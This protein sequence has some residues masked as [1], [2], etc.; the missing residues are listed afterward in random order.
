M[1]P[2]IGHQPVRLG[3]LG[4]GRITRALL[5][6]ARRTKAVE[7]VA[8]GSRTVERA[9]E[10][11]AEQ[12]IARS[13]GSY[14]AFLADP[15]VEA[16]YI[17]LPNSLH[18]PWTL[19]ALEAGTHV[20]CEKPYSRRPADVVTAFDAADRAGLVLTEGFM[21]RHHPQ[22]RTIGEL[23]A[24]L[25]ELQTVRATFSFVIE[26]Q[27]DV[28][29]RSD[30]DGGSLMDV[31][32]YCISGARLL[33]GEEPDLAFGVQVVGPTGVD[34]RFNGLLHFPGGAIAEFMS[35]FEADHRGLEAIGSD[36]SVRLTNPWLPEDA[37]YVRDGVE[38]PFGTFDPY[39]LELQDFSRAIR[40]RRPPLLGR[41]DALG[42]ARAI[43]ALYRSAASGV[44]IR[45]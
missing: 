15:D 31:G 17:S 9:A 8:V 41:A 19:R 40:E 42:Q 7:V 28:R 11:A 44:P 4:T 30:L 45:L 16:V 12:G 3:I 35:G 39:Q 32:T 21:W 6:G 36:G 2:S 37:S 20:L 25:G 18:H 23:L 27:S 26:H 13:H 5:A 33:T 34:V 14:E 1:E 10:F 38:V 29:L 43:D 22:A 24:D